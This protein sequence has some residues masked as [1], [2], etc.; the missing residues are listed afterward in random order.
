M[1]GGEGLKNGYVQLKK[2][3]IQKISRVDTFK[4]SKF[5]VSIVLIFASHTSDIPVF[6]VFV[7]VL[8]TLIIDRY[9]LL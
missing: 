9:I 6:G 1:L 8:Y 4:K 7:A 3:I 5:F 2:K